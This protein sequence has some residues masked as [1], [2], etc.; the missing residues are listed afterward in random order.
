MPMRPTPAPIGWPAR[1]LALVLTAIVVAACGPSAEEPSTVPPAPD[2][3][4]EDGTDDDQTGTDDGQD[5]QTGPDDDTDDGQDDQTDTDD[6]PDVDALAFIDCETDR[7]TVGYPEGWNTNRGQELLDACRIFHPGEIDEPERPRD[8]DLQYA[9]SLY[10]DQVGLDDVDPLEVQGEVLDQRETTVDGR[11]AVL[12]EY[13]STGETLTPE[14]ERSTTWTI[15]LDGEILVATTS[16]VGDTDYERDQR[17]LERMVTDELTIHDRPTGQAAPIGGPETTQRSTQEP[18]G[19]PLWVTDVRVG[20]HGSF[21][22]VTFEIGGDGQVG[23][24]IEYDE[25]PTSQG[26]GD[27]VDIAG[28]AV[29][30]VALRGMGYPTMPEVPPYEGPAQLQPERTEAIVEVLE[31]VLYEGYYDFFVGLDTERPYRLERLEDPQRVVIDIM[32]D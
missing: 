23:W 26:R 5:D 18:D 31:D 29:L 30:R 24:L 21:D 20:H 16:S 13:R 6:G 11:P 9:V 2:N 17:V 1:L 4:T 14:G 8:R 22:R 27:P 19:G 32:L 10:I 28:D 3:G 12:V 7:Y 25:N 15:D